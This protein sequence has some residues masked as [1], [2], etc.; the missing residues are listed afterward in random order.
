MLLADMTNDPVKHPRIKDLASIISFTEVIPA[1]TPKDIPTQQSGFKAI[2]DILLKN[3][4]Q[5]V[6]RAVYFPFG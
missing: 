4:L 3:S 5:P 6:L 1:I 2:D